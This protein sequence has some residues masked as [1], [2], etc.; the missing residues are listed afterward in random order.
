MA[1]RIKTSEAT[2]KRIRDTGPALPRVEPARVQEALG[3]EPAAEGVHE[4]L[5]P[6]TLYTVREE[7]V[8]RLQ[9]RG[10]RPGLFGVS[11]RA[12]IPLSDQEWLGLEALA[13]A[14]SSPGFAPSAGQVASV[15]LTLSLQ[16]LATRAVGSAPGQLPAAV[17]QE[18][19]ALAAA[20]SEPGRTKDDS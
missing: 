7:L 2:Y 1:D 18:L 10:G 14:I 4:V 6:L 13:A 12:K 8:R 11:R 3:A 17:V 19:A 20:D 5:A 16:A 15:L 9:S